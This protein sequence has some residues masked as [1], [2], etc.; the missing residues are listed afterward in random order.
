MNPTT[1]L[2]KAMEWKSLNAMHK[3][4]AVIEAVPENTVMTNVPWVQK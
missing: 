3:V 4:E 2:R 1:I